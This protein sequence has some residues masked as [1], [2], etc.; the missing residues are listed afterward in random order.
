ML[1]PLSDNVF[2]LLL[3]KIIKKIW[4]EWKKQEKLCNITTALEKLKEVKM[5]RE[6]NKIITFN[7][8]A[9]E[10]ILDCFGKE[11]DK[12]GYIVEKDTKEAV[13]TP[14]GEPLEL[15]E[16]AGIRKGSQIFFKSDIFSIIDLVDFMRREGIWTSGK[17][18]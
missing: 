4:K 16:F 7:E 11:V 14:D 13:L 15:E 17:Q 6:M 18:S 5:E 8:S 3:V 12:E 9:K 2:K 1:I 10:F